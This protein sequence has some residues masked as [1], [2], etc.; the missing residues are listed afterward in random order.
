MP[1]EKYTNNGFVM[2]DE[3]VKFISYNRPDFKVLKIRNYFQ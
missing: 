3:D 1:S 2:P